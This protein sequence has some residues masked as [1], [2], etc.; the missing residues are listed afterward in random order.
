MDANASSLPRYIFIGPKGGGDEP[1]LLRVWERGVGETLA[2]GTGACAATVAAALS[3]RGG[4]SAEVQLPGGTLSVS[5]R[6]DGRVFMTGPAEEVFSGT[7][8]VKVHGQ[9]SVLATGAATEL[10]GIGAALRAISPERTRLQREI[11]RIVRVV[12][13]AGVGAA[14][15]VVVIYGLTRGLAAALVHAARPGPLT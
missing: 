11:D 1:I 4:R 10:G 15:A 14:A 3:C 8:V 5:W 9:A 13:V 12:A 7:L 2:C 6:E